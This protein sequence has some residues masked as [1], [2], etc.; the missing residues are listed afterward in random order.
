MPD[1]STTYMG[2]ELRN[3]II[4]GSSGLSNSPEKVESCAQA[5]AGAVVL[6]SIF[7][8][9]INEAYQKM[10]KENAWYPEAADYVRSY[11]RQNAVSNYLDLISDSKS[12]VDVPIIASIHCVSPGAWTEFASRAAKAGADAIELNVFVLPT[13]TDLQPS[14]YDKIYIDI[15][16]GV[17]AKVTVPVSM[18]IGTHFSSLARM[19]MILNH[20]GADGLILFNRFLRMDIDI[21]DISLVPGGSLSVPSETLVPL[22]WVSLLSK[23]IHCDI[24]GTTGIHS[25]VEVVKHLLAG[26]TA[27][28]VCSCLYQNGVEYID[29]LLAGLDEWMR[30]RGFDTID[31]FRGRLA[32]KAERRATAWERVQYMKE[33]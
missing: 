28:Q 6:K 27:I 16:Q 10:A 1:L 24:A 5:G 30:S 9:E 25:W 3:P 32:R 11:G 14:D 33:D 29:K 17:R 31:Q 19:A 15:L 22:R 7:E 4:V 18:K 12:R 2:L 23:S 20:Y 26:A 21:D 13:D 8:E